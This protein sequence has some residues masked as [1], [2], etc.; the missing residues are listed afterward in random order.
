MSWLDPGV[1]AG[2]IGF[3]H[4]PLE[5]YLESIVASFLAGPPADRPAGYAGRAVELALARG[6]PGIA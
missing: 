1:A 2:E 5:G 6:T 3:V 4:R